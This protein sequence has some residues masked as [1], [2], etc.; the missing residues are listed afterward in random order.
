MLI[1]FKKIFFILIISNFIG[2]PFALSQNLNLCSKNYYSKD[3]SFQKKKIKNIDIKVNDYRGWQVNN[4]R[5]LT[6]NSHVISEKFKKRFNSKII[7]YYDDKSSCSYKAKIRT[8]GDLKDHIFYKDGNVFQ[9]LDVTLNDGHVNNIVKFKLF[10]EGTRGKEEDEI[11]MTELLRELGFLAPRTEIV[12]VSLN[13]QNIK[14]LFQEKISKELLEY[15]KR[16][17]GPILEGDEKY[18]MSFISKVKNNPKIDWGEIFRLSD[19][20]TKIQL[21]K[22]TNS[23]WSIKDPKFTEI[24][25]DALQ[26]LNFVYLVYLNSY[27]DKK[28]DYFFL[29]YYLDNNLLAQNNSLNLNKLNTYNNLILAANGGH[30][31]YVHNRKFYWN[32]VENYFEPIYYDGEFN[33]KK[34]TNKLHY[35]LSL[36]Y[37]E[38][39]NNTLNL[40]N[41]LDNRKLLANINDRNLVLDKEQFNKKINNL[42]K[43]LIE[44]KKL[45]KIKKKEELIYNL[46]SYK[47]KPLFNNYVENLEKQRIKYKFAKYQYDE[48]TKKSYL[49][50]CEN[51]SEK[52]DENL[53]LSTEMKRELL[54]GK[55]KINKYDYQLIEN[56][57][58]KLI[59]YK[60]VNLNDENFNDVYFIFNSGIRYNYDK[61]S[62]KFDIYQLN[63]EGRAFFL[64]GKIKDLD[65]KFNGKESQYIDKQVVKYDQNNLTGCLS[66]IKNTFEKTTLN[67]VHSNCEDGINLIDTIGLLN[68]INVEYSVLDGVDL[69]FSDLFIRNIKIKDSGNDCIDFS[70]GK[71]QVN[72]F[73]LS[74]CGDKAISVGEKSKIEIENV[75]IKKALIGIASK[76][77]SQVYIDQ[78]KIYETDDCLAAYRKKQEFDGGFLKIN[79]SECQNFKRALFEDK[80]S[81]I[82]IANNIK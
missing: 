20:G 74:N 14:M 33:L 56:S 27:K 55:L 19:L 68:S 40:I 15:N 64:N 17:E 22:Q 39:I 28:N 41:K 34:K 12:N 43:N 36:D 81:K 52:C 65:I 77:S 49:R 82:E 4:I 26:K 31:L 80:F 3:Y 7:I 62:K 5:I 24:S 44:I 6:N 48:K 69:D 72:F 73:N 75:N 67:A 10:L 59:K 23:S 18:M 76:D 11:F 29:D 54:E 25:L 79:S 46:S 35:P 60:K 42:K 70:Y 2:S 50:I 16:R 51:K 58:K 57:K 30:G 66:F 9:S 78:S 37:E 71:Y 61:I 45:F 8:Q 13:N 38:S 21:S 47:N 53:L 32:S 1:L 63:T